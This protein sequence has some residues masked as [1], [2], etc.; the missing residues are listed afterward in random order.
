MKNRKNFV[1]TDMSPEVKAYAVIHPLGFSAEDVFDSV[2]RGKSGLKKIERDFLANPVYAACFTDEQNRRLK[3]LCPVEGWNR[4]EQLIWAAGKE[5]LEKSEITPDDRVL[6]VIA[7]TK[8]G[9]EDV[10]NSP[11][12]LIIHLSV[13]RVIDRLLFTYRDRVGEGAPVYIVSNACISGLSAIMAGKRFLEAQNRDY[14]III[15]ADTV[16]DFVLS[17]FNSLFALDSLPCRPFDRSRNGINL[18]EG[19]AAVVLHR[20]G[21]RDKC[22]AGSG[23]YLTGGAITNDA[24]HISGPSRTGLELAEAIR[25]AVSATNNEAKFDFLSAHGT[26]TIYNDEMES[27]AFAAAGVADIPIHSLKPCLGHTLGA[28]GV[29]ESVICI[30]SLVD[31][32]LIPSS[33]YSE[34]GTSNKLN[35]QTAPEHREITRFIKTMSGFGGCNAAVCFEKR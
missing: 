13:K 34:N 29:M 31:N 2:V 35:I 8:G 6:F 14:A 27:R 24:N 30:R 28:A 21:H 12:N 32:I 5:V 9:I 4:F 1:E 26:A 23:I 15:G 20:N 18:G 33:G 17:G 22:R 10:E 7:T 11:D 25:R 19:A 16:N 3:S